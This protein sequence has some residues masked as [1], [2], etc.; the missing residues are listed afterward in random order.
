MVNAS[1]AAA[2][3]AAQSCSSAED[4]LVPEAQADLYAADNVD[5]VVTG[6]SN[7][8]EMVGCDVGKGHLSVEYLTQQEL[9]FAGVLGFGNSGDVRT[10]ATAAWGPA[11]GGKRCRS[12]W[13][14]ATCRASATCPTACRSVTRAR[15]TTTTGTR[16]S[17]MRTGAS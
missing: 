7:I 17:A 13:I 6:T 4:A 14:R 12:W 11:A 10:A 8:T 3:A 16:A 1:D 2:L 5:G 15:C 9:F